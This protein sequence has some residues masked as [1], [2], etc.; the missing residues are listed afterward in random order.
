LKCLFIAWLFFEAPP[1]FFKKFLKKLPKKYLFLKKI[2]IFKSSTYLQNN[3]TI[4]G[5]F[6]VR[7]AKT[8]EELNNFTKFLL[9]DVQALDRMLKEGWFETDTIRIGAE[10]EMCLVDSHGKPS[11]KNIKVLEK[12]NSPDFTTEL[13]RFNIEANVPPLTFTGTCFSDMENNINQLMGQLRNVLGDMDDVD[14]VLTGI[15]P[16]IRKFDINMD[17]LTP[18]VRY[19]SLMEAINNMRGNRY[20][21]RIEGVDELNVMLDSPLVEAC[22]TSFQVHLQI[23]PEEFAAKYNAAQ[24][25]AAPVLAL[26]TNSPLVFGKRLW[27]ETRIAL[28]RQS[29]DTRVATEHL[30]ERSPRVMF[31]NKWVKDSLIEIYKEDIMRFRV[32]FM[33]DIEE[34]VL[35][36]VEQGITPR[37]RALNIHNSTVY[38]WNRPCYGISPNG[39][40]HLRIENRV[41]PAGPSVVDEVSNAAFWIGVMNGFEDAYKDVTK[42]MDFDE[43]KSN[44]LLAA[45]N[46]LGVKYSWMGKK[47][48]DTE[49]IAKELLPLAR[50]GLKKANVSTQDIDKYLGI[51]EARNETGYT[52]SRWMLNSYAK[53]IKETSKEEVMVAIT[54][55]T[56]NYQ[57][58]NLPVHTW[59]LATMKDIAE[60]EPS[61]I[62]VEEFMTTDL[63]TVNKDD[64]PD[65]SADIM[66]WQ[67]I[68]YIPVEDMKGSLVGLI[69]S[70]MLLRHFLLEKRNGTD[71]KTL[72]EDLMIKNP[73]T[74]SPQATIN[75]ALEIMTTK[76]IGCLPVVNK[77]NLVGIITESN[78]L[79]ITASLIKRLSAKNLKATENQPT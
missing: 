6:S 13:A 10:Q 41:L 74:I 12:L 75:E 33:T 66:D 44:F 9:K 4:M 60:Y 14:V 69:S 31:G 57:K 72:I 18:V 79:N 35:Q 24:A 67:R 52:G 78:F 2:L 7:L 40:P 23:K 29:I 1:L 46:G 76:Q 19:F 50:H 61:A 56:M 68:R 51:I 65:L 37:L 27:S 16:T 62:L 17:N 64:L 58:Q 5:D 39:K 20:E 55:A 8:Q 45:R 47:I 48:N 70:R 3:K 59:D 32:I 15:L 30:R 77:G 49:L 63:F 38:R 73:I 21:L 34:D 42:L 36:C 54:S 53:L 71:S 22:N 25:I 26:G 28:F 11:P 43:A